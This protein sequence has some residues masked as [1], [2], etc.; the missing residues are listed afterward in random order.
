MIYYVQPKLAGS[1]TRLATLAKEA[2][3]DLETSQGS[4]LNKN[5]LLEALRDRFIAFYLVLHFLFMHLR[6]GD[7][8]P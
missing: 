8:T 3:A 7:Y 5:H 2:S 6:L 1:L 4:I